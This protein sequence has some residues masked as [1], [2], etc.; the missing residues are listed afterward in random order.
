MYIFTNTVVETIKT[1]C[2]SILCSTLF[3]FMIYRD[4][5]LFQDTACFILNLSA[6]LLFLFLYHKNWADFYSRTYTA[7]E[8][9]I[10]AA[11]SFL[12]YAGL[13]TY[14]YIIRASAVY[15]WLFQHTR[16]LEPLLNNDYAFLSF[17]LSQVVTL[18][19]LVIAPRFCY[20]K[21]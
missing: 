4:T 13:S 3:S 21:R 20:Q 17:I 11:S 16:F 18:I 10:P 12:V 19:V 15:R 6:F 1:F 9:I 14:L 2:M 8:Y 5:V 7:A